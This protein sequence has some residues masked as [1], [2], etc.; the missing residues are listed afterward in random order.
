MLG[1]CK[2]DPIVVGKP[3]AFMLD[4]IANKFD[5]R[6]AGSAGQCLPRHGARAKAWCLLVHAE[7]SLSHG[8]EGECLVPPSNIRVTSVL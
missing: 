4:Y 1:S 3:A 6:K 2:R 5:I 8:A 7:A